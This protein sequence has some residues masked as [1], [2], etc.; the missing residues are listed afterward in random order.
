[1]GVRAGNHGHRLCRVADR[2]YRP[3]RLIRYTGWEGAQ[4]VSG[5]SVDP[6][7]CGTGTGEEAARAP[8]CAAP[9]RS[10][11]C[12]SGPGIPGRLLA[13]HLPRSTAGRTPSAPAS[14]LAGCPVRPAFFNDRQCPRPGA[15]SSLLP[16]LAITSP[17]KHLPWGRIARA[18]VLPAATQIKHLRR[19]D[20]Q[21]FSPV[22]A[23]ETGPRGLRRIIRLD[24]GG[25]ESAMAR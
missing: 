17:F 15:A 23:G 1:V 18:N 5:R 16:R 7:Q 25:H 3:V 20:R 4:P 12:S 24:V 21:R 22:A 11:C 14:C 2:R 8:R 10:L 13:I 19:A 6:D 9:E